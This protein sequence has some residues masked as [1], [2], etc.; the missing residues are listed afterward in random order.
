[1]SSITLQVAATS[2][3]LAG[4]SNQPL[5]GSPLIIPK[6]SGVNDEGGDD[7]EGGGA[8]ED[9]PELASAARAAQAAQEP[10][11]LWTIFGRGIGLEL[12]H[13]LEDGSHAVR[14]EA[15]YVDL[16]NIYLQPTSIQPNPQ[17]DFSQS[18][19]TLCMTSFTFAFFFMAC[20]CTSHRP[21]SYSSLHEVALHHHV[22]VF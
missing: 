20:V 1:M 3:G 18:V 5:I 12:L 19:H 4:W 15:A 6:Q 13:C 9:D 17:I 22:L 2:V 11:L 7:D 10:G 21:T 16:T 14:L 8:A